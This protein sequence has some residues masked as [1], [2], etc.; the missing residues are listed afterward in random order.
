M[1]APHAVSPADRLTWTSTATVAHAQPDEAQEVDD[2]RLYAL[3]SPRSVRRYQSTSQGASLPVVARTSIQVTRHAIPKRAT[4]QHALAHHPPSLDRSLHEQAATRR[5]HW[6]TIVGGILLVMLLGWVLMTVFLAWWNGYQDD[7]RYGRP[8]TFQIDAV[9]GH[10]DS[11]THPSHFI[12]QHLGNHYYVI[13]LAGGDPANMRV[14]VPMTAIGSGPDL[15]PITL[16]FKDVNHDG[17]PDMIVLVG[18]TRAI[19]INDHG[20]FRPLN[21]GDVVS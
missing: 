10:A 16:Q 1:K 19:F 21:A 12:A 14:I 15:T 17:R 18:Q 11:P 2:E 9:V 3:R 8:R 7:L 4:A 13:E 20:T 6:L 5:M